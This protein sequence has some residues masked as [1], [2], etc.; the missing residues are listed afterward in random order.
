MVDKIKFVLDHLVH[1]GKTG[2]VRQHVVL[3]RVA[4]AGDVETFRMFHVIML[5]NISVYSV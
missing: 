5:Q 2:K 4:G 3:V 1:D